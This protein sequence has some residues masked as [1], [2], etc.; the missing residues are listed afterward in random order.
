MRSITTVFGTLLGASLFITA[1]ALA[2]SETAERCMALPSDSE[3]IECLYQ[4]LLAAE[5]ALARA[6]P[7]ETPPEVPAPPPL[8]PAAPANGL[9]QLGEEQIAVRQRDFSNSVEDERFEATVVDFRE[10]VPGR[11]MFQ[12]DN[13]QVWQQTG[14]DA[15]RLRLPRDEKI[16][17]ELWGSW[18]GGYRML[19]KEQNLIARVERLR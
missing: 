11:M 12:L 19:L 13:G 8:A 14:G 3:R 17:V 7:A 10:R 2:Q 5:E 15:Q 16:A 9:A 18:S 6:T 1:P 4:A